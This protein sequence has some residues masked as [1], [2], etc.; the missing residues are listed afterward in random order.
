MET[1]ASISS[2]PRTVEE[3]FVDYRGRRTAIVRALTTGK[4]LFTFILKFILSSPKLE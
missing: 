3:V 4:K 1:A 2:N